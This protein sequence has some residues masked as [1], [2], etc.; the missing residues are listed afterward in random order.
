ME[1]FAIEPRYQRCNKLED[2]Y[3]FQLEQA[4][5]WHNFAK[6]TAYYIYNNCLIIPPQ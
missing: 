5:A 2:L 6:E 1:G 3:M 4:T